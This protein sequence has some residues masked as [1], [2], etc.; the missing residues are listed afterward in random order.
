MKN[1]PIGCSEIEF[2]KTLLEDNSNFELAVI[3]I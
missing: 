2:K 1:L 3:E